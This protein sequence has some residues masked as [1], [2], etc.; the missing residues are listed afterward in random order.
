VRR[1]GEVGRLPAPGDNVAIATGRLEAGTEVER[2]GSR[3]RISHTVLEGHRFAA[4]PI[5]EGEELLSWGLPFGRAL[6]DIAPGDYVCNEKI[7]RVLRER[8]PISPRRDGG[9]PDGTHDQG[10]GQIPGGFRHLHFVLPEEPNFRD[11]ELT[12]YELDEERFRPG[13]P[14]PLYDEPGT[15]MGYRR[16][17]GRGVG[18]RNHVLVLGVNSRTNSFAKMLEVRLNDLAERYENIDGVVAVAHT[19]GG[20]EDA[21]NNLEILLRTLSGFAVHPNVA[22]V[23]V[24]DGGGG[25]VSNRMLR[26]YMEEHG[27]PLADVRH[28]FMSLG[29]SFGQDLDRGEEILRGWLPEVD[30][31]RRTEEPLSELKFALQ[32]GG[33]DAFSGVSANPL[34]GWLAKEVIKHGG[35]AI[36]AET[37]EL[38]GAEPY[39]LDNVRD[40]ET[41]RRFLQ[42]IERFK[43]LVGWH[44]HTAEG[45]PSGGN[46]YRGL[47]N[48]SIKSIGAAAKKDPEVRIEHVI[49]YAERMRE[50][51]YHFMDSPG[52]DLE[53]VAG[54]VASG[55][56]LI[57]FTTGNGSITNFPFVPTI[58][59]VSTT[60]RYNLLPNEMDVNAGAYLD[61]LPMEDLGRE[62]FD[63]SV[64]AASGERTVGEKAGHSQ[65]QIW[66]DWK[67]TGTE[68]LER[69]LSAPAPD[70][71]PLPIKTDPGVADGRSF[72]AVETE[73]GYATDQVALVMPTN[74]CSSQI[75]LKIAG[76]LNERGYG[77]GRVSRFVALPHT[78]GCGNSGGSSMELY[79]RTVLGHLDHPLVRFALLLEHGCE[80]THND[81]FRSR[82]IEADLDPDRFGWASVQLDGGIEKVTRK[83]ED[84][85]AAELEAADELQYEAAGLRHLRLGLMAT[86]PLPD[87]AALSLA[88]LTAIIVGAGGTVVVPETASLLRSRAYL[89]GTVGDAEVRNT[90]AHGQVA[91]KPGFH[92]MEAPTSN[93][94]EAATGLAATGVEV[95]LAHVSGRPLQAHRMIPLLQVS[96]DPETTQD[97]SEDLDVIL[98]GDPST[99]TEDLL[100]SVLDVASRRYTPRLYGQ[101]NVGFQLTRGLLGVSM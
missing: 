11:A 89:D 36:L 77:E 12:A 54:E 68:N 2:D 44:G 65:A 78:E 16:P 90:L 47:Y 87:A 21:P 13:S 7:L 28:E 20:E 58:K 35:A 95:M 79:D 45:N 40:L 66:R 10:P 38:I 71:E 69:I 29:R 33:S 99:W 14:V 82:L 26:S 6:E 5:A 1:F 19:E 37:D 24:V 100:A 53:S 4:E 52:N 85:F 8:H 98:D 17:G 73:R 18:T 62:T 94:T 48:I 97:H 70:G 39:V 42:T 83:V 92:V 76:S 30:A 57:F 25:A 9:E 64:R 80:K 56:N 23:L 63:L 41:A 49:D 91:R 3:F 15:F 74:L 84:W 81:Y 31:M 101:G 93:P 75:A 32:C 51:G 88:E 86:G 43:E 50:A 27:Y 96:A 55:C 60:G 22:A 72:E 59:V 67:Q 46:N 61:G 34:I